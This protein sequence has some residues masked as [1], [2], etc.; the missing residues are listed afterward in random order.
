MMFH[1][2]TGLLVVFVHCAH[3]FPYGAPS[4]ACSS[5]TPNHLNNVPSEGGD[6]L[7]ALDVVGDADAGYTG[8]YAQDHL[9]TYV[10]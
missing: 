1:V 10:C 8:K 3:A 9:V 4:S 6:D 2:L 7:F 5:M